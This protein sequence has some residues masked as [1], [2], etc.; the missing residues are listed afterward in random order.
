MFLGQMRSIVGP[1]VCVCVWINLDCVSYFFAW[2]NDVQHF[3][4][5]AV[6]VNDKIDTLIELN[7]LFLMYQ[8]QLH[9]NTETQNE[10]TFLLFVT[11]F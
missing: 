4:L 7:C 3:Y 8:F 6:L 2:Q 5:A 11:L 10:G 9:M 1:Y